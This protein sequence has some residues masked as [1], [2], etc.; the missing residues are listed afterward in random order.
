MNLQKYGN[1]N[2][3]KYVKLIIFYFYFN[4]SILCSANIILRKKYQKM[5]KFS[6]KKLLINLLQ[7]KT[8]YGSFLLSLLSR[9]SINCTKKSLHSKTISLDL[10]KS[11]N[12]SDT[13]LSKYS[14]EFLYWFLTAFT[15]F[16]ISSNNYYSVTD[17]Y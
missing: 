11:A 1:V 3:K 7:S 5:A 4:I 16:L 12:K 14:T 15:N 10:D 9:I 6:I 8:I 13:F 2:E 17:N